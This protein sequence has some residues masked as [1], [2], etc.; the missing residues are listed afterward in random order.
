M[1]D[2]SPEQQ[3][4]IVFT[5]FACPDTKSGITFS[6]GG[7]YVRKIVKHVSVEALSIIRNN[8]PDAVIPGEG[9]GYDDLKNLKNLGITRDHVIPVE[10]LFQHFD[11]LNKAHTLTEKTILGFLP[12]LEIAIITAEENRKF[13]GGLSARMPSGWW[14][15][16]ALDPFDRYRAAELDDGIWTTEFLHNTATKKSQKKSRPKGRK[17][18]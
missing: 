5:R 14:E 8:I 10:D 18:K 4:H 12:K 16:K 1:K 9:V 13:R 17:G 11:A 2:C 6:L 15:S 3:A 7:L